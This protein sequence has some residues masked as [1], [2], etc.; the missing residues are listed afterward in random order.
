MM[1]ARTLGAIGAVAAILLIAQPSLAAVLAIWDFG[2]SSAFYTLSPAY[3]NTVA[4]PTMTLKDNGGL[5]ADGKNGVAYTDAAGVDHIAGQAAAWDDI[6]KSSGGNASAIVTLNTTGFD[7]LKIRWDYKSE[8]ATSFDFAYR[9]AADGTWTQVADNKAITTGWD[10]NLWG[11]A[12]IDLSA[13]TAINGQSYVQ[14]RLD[15]LVEGPGND[16]FAF[17]NFEITGT[18][19]PEPATLVLLGLGGLLLRGKKRSA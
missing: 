11:T 17:D 4:A 7:T 1:R 16:K 15:D 14:L 18:R 19:V 8:K 12:T 9:T 3:Y 5:D 13:A 10:A 6:K 2:D